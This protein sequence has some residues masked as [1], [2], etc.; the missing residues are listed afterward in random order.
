MVSYQGDT[1]YLG[2][3]M[4]A[5][6]FDIGT[7]SSAVSYTYLYP[8]DYARANVGTR[9]PGQPE[10]VGSSKACQLTELI[11][12]LLAYRNGECKAIGAETLEHVDAYDP[13]DREH[14]ERS[15][16]AYTSVDGLF[17]IPHLFGV[18][19]RKGMRMESDF[20]VQEK[21]YRTSKTLQDLFKAIE[22]A[23]YVYDGDEVPRW[24][25][26]TKGKKLPQIRHLCS[27]KA[28][29]SNLQGSLQPHKG[30]QG[31]YYR[32]DYTVSIRLG[33]TKLE[34]RLQWKEN[35]TLR[36]GPI[37]ILPGALV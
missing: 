4:V 24:I 10:S 6:A 2:R 3:E 23:I 17:K 19:I 7:T 30:P 31:P 5:L 29:M 34:A 14:R 12:T 15:S 8:N 22:Y 36:E 16:L 1:K 9:W 25:V 26:N 11:P 35:G 32:A 20:A 27:L 13:E 28:D 18:L 37:T 33:G 21:L